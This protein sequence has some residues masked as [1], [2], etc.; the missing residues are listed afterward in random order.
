MLAEERLREGLRQL[1]L[2]VD[3]DMQKK[4]LAYLQLMLKWNKAYNL[5]AIRAL[6]EMVIRHLLDSLSIMPY[7]KSSPVLD[8]GTGAGLPGIPLAICMPDC[9]F[10]LLDSNGKKTRFLVQAK[11]ELDIENI[12]VIHSRVEDYRPSSGF[13][14]I[15]CRAFAALNTLLDR[16]QH[17]VTSTTRVMAMKAREDRVVLAEG[18]KQPAQHKLQVPGLN[19]ERHLLEITPLTNEST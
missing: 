15:T 14:I 6:D 5:T 17:L 16:T 9:Q 19:E 11:I 1:E 7:I 3:T 10:V 2:D 12:D 4:L 13:E 18:F 8:V